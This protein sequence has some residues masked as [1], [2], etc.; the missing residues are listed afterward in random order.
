VRIV[1]RIQCMLFVLLLLH[2]WTHM[3]MITLTG[4]RSFSERHTGL[5]CT[6][7]HPYF[8]LFFKNNFGVLVDLPRTLLD[9]GKKNIISPTWMIVLIPIIRLC[10]FR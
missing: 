8:V 5:R 4:K 10:D 3:C 2:F 1:Y 9:F 6:H 7:L